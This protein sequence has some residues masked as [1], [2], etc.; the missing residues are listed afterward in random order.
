MLDERVDGAIWMLGLLFSII[1]IG[2]TLT[3]AGYGA[4]A[5]IWA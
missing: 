1:I 3:L 4:Y 2:G 5:L